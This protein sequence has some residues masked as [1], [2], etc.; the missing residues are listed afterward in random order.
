M[1][2]VKRLLVLGLAVIMCLTAFAISSSANE[3]FDVKVNMAARYSDDGDKI[4]ISVTTD[5]PA[6]AMKATLTYNSTYVTLDESDTKFIENTAADT[7]AKAEFYKADTNGKITFVVT[8]KDLDKGNTHW[9]DVYF[10]IDKDKLVDDEDIVFGLEDI[11]V[12]DVTETLDN[13]VT[14]ENESVEIESKVLRGLGSQFRK[15]DTNPENDKITEDAMRFGARTEINAGQGEALVANKVTI[16]GKEYNLKRCG[17]V[18]AP[19]FY[20]KE[21][22]DKFYVKLTDPKSSMELEKFDPKVSVKWTQVSKYYKYDAETGY[23]VYTLVFLAKGNPDTVWC[24]RPYAIYENPS[25]ADGEDKYII[26]FGNVLSNS[27]NGVQ[28]SVTTL[29]QDGFGGY[30]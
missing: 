28:Q 26:R 25:P 20:I 8:A 17:F 4:I 1:K 7:D 11:Q 18:W 19:E 12:C 22:L 29:N 27:Y 23:F 10:N 9:A 14:V 21:K 30:N 3:T 5:K 16:D 15:K 2:R 13:G 24:A 6:G